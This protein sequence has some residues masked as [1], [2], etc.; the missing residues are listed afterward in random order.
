MNVHDLVLEWSESVMIDER[1]LVAGLADDDLIVSVLT[2]K[3]RLLLSVPLGRVVPTHLGPQRFE[4]EQ[5][6][7]GVLKLR[8]SLLDPQLHAFITIVG[9]PLRECKEGDD[10]TD[11]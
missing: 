7:P 11:P 9:A 4:L 5:I 8:P 3:G 2:D 10:V 6:Y 1:P